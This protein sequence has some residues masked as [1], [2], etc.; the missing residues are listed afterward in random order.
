MLN[1]NK[2]VPLSLHTIANAICMIPIQGHLLQ[3]SYP[4]VYLL[5]SEIPFSV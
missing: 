1:Q 2:R 4:L 3:K 5:K